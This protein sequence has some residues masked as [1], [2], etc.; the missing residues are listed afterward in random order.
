ML[1]TS[2]PAARVGVWWYGLRTWIELGFRTLKR[3]G[4]HWE[5]TRRTDPERVARHWLVLA[6]A[7]LWTVATGT[8]EEDAARLGRDPTH[9]HRPRPLP[10]EP[11][12]H[13][14][15]SCFHRGLARLR[16][17]LCRGRPW[18]RALWLCP[19]PW[20]DPPT[21]LVIHRFD[22]RAGPLHL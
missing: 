14:T 17:Q 21:T 6:V 15:V 13:R 2:V 16:W 12:W 9:L 19:E 8:R 11:A 20:P 18:W 7:T 10:R 4:W 1:L 3:G 5:R 22:P